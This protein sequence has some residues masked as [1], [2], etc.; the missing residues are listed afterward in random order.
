MEVIG[1]AKLFWNKYI[2]YVQRETINAKEHPEDS[3]CLEL[4]AEN[5]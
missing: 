4:H 5:R 1:K 2:E 3:W